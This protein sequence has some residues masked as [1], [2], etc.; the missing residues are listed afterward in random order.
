MKQ[1]LLDDDLYYSA[2]EG[3]LSDTFF[4]ALSDS[5]VSEL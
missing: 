2:E 4:D 1:T 5:P 3:S